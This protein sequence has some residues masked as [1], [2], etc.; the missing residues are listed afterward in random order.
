LVPSSRGFGSSLDGTAKK[1]VVL[2]FLVQ[3]WIKIRV[4]LTSVIGMKIVEIVGQHT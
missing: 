4:S 2:N 3:Y 1:F